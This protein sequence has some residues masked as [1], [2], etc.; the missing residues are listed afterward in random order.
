MSRRLV[1]QYLN[2][3]GIRIKGP[4][5]YG[6]MCFC[7][8]H[9]DINKPSFSVHGETGWWR[10]FANCGEGH[11]AKLTDRM[12]LGPIFLPRSANPRTEPERPK[13]R[14]S[15]GE[16]LFYA[17]YISIPWLLR[18][19]DTTTM[20]HFQV[21]FD[22]KT[23]D[24]IFPVRQPD[25]TPVALIHSRRK[26]GYSYRG[27]CRR[28][29][30]WGVHLALDWDDPLVL[31]EGVGDVMRIWQLGRLPAVA[32]MGSALTPGQT[33]WLK[34]L[35][36]P[37]ICMLD[38]D[39]AGLRGHLQIWNK[40]RRYC[41]LRFVHWDIRVKDPGELRSTRQL[42]HLLGGVKPFPKTLGVQIE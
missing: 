20:D 26:G 5:D 2:L 22:P 39:T 12:G 13:E 4:N 24:T 42:D 19:F 29:N 7:P 31:C 11:F 34:R 32:I 8:F 17:Q 25:G 9:R 40:L 41:Q 27:D 28:E 33:R 1:E 16:I 15:E 21:G 35:R 38:N 3:M 30:F 10:C 37:V 18:G 36:R 6:F 14:P 23:G